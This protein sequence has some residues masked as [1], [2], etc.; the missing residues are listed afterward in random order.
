VA[1][2]SWLSG[3]FILITNA[4]MQHPVGYAVAAD[5]LLRLESIWA[6]LLNPWAAVQF[7]HNQAAALVTGAFVVTALGAFY[8]LAD[9]DR[10]QARM[11]LKHGAIAGLLASMIV[12]F[13]TGDRQAKYVARYQEPSLAAMEGRFESGTMA[14]I[15][16]IGQPDVQH[17]RLDNAIR[18][19]G[20]L[21]FLAYG[22]FRDEVRGLE[23]FPQDTWPDNIELLYYSFHIMAGLGTLF[24]L[25]M[26]LAAAY[27]AAGKLEGNRP[28][29]W[30]LMLAFPFPYIANTVGWMTAELGRQ[31]WLVYGLYRTE[32]G[33]SSVVSSGSAIFTLIGF[34]GLY[35]VI[36]V[37]FLFLA[38]REIALGPE[39]EHG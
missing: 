34:C 24:I 33:Y 10:E 7:S 30:V 35:F 12:A 37:L 3:F 1:A 9:R 17:R 19:P 32:Q 22:G 25:V 23:E 6:Y 18:I 36:G 38:G 11:Y 13:P 8:V 5:G 15:D 16:L 21:S 4:F 27:L 2:G 14:A 29:L 20:A 31:P 39:A 26:G 28:L